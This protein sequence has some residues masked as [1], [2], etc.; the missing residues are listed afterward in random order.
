MTSTD[1]SQTV[2]G[3]SVGHLGGHLDVRAMMRHYLPAF[4]LVDQWTTDIN[5]PRIISKEGEIIKV[6]S[7]TCPEHKEEAIT[8]ALKLKDAIWLP[9]VWDAQHELDQ[10]IA[11]PT[12]EIVRQIL[13]GMLQILR[14]KPTEGAAVYVDGLVFELTEPEIGKPF[15][16]PAIVAAARETW[17]AQ[18]FAPSISEFMPR[19]RKY[20]LRIDMVRAQ[21]NWLENTFDAVCEVLEQLAPETLP[22]LLP[23]QIGGGEDDVPF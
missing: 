15:C 16:G 17:N 12:E 21:L 3:G 23:S 19:V 20:Q 9:D 2:T 1:V 10:L 6:Y 18:T 4:K 22:K 5:I 7:W 13:I 11:R 8:E 14:S